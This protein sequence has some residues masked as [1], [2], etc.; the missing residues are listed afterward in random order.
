MVQINNCDV[1]GLPSI[2]KVTVSIVAENVKVAG[3]PTGVAFEKELCGNC[4]A[5]SAP[6]MFA[7]AM[8]ALEAAIAA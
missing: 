1:C 7:E 2:G 3:S 6:I 4:R 8:A 5:A